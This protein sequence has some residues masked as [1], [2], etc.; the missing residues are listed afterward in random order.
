MKKQIYGAQRNHLHLGSGNV[1]KKQEMKTKHFQALPRPGV[2]KREL[3][4]T[5]EAAT[6]SHQLPPHPRGDSLLPG[7]PS[8]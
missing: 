5:Q 4:R 7:K 1:K 3:V 2:G 6:A 8:P